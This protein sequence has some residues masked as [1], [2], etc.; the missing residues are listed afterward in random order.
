[1]KCLPILLAG[2]F[3]N[4][5]YPLSCEQ[6]PKQFIKIIKNNKSIFQKNIEIIRQIL[7]D[8]DIIIVCNL[9]HINLIKKQLKEI[10][11]KKY[12]L[13]L[14]QA[15]RNTFASILLVLKFIDE[16][17]NKSRKY[18]SIFISPSDSYISQRNNAFIKTFQNVINDSLNM[19]NHIIFGTKINNVNVNFGYIK[20]NLNNKK[21][22]E[23]KQNPIFLKI[24]KFVEKPTLN[25][26]TKMFNNGNYLWNIGSFI[27][28]IDILKQEIKKYTK[29]DY[30]IYQYMR[31]IPYKQ[32][33]N[34][35]ISDDSFLKL[36]KISIDKAIVEK[37][38]NFVCYK[39]NFEWYDIG[40][41]DII[42]RLINK[43][44]ITLSHKSYFEANLAK[45]LLINKSIL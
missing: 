1:M 29:K 41:F 17:Q 25:M 30:K 3:G 16:I 28:N 2:G 42:S 27:F 24:Q 12:T 4:R 32:T 38:K 33:K 36:S 21:Q 11:E 6:Q 43:N 34:I 31:L 26:A 39:T 5:L 37:S 15:S 13:L 14:E 18:H 19:N 7:P 10:N 20:T 44:K 22:C 35:L 45:N 8:E 40:S 9:L 23:N